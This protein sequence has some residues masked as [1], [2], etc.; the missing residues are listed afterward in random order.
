[1]QVSSN[2][3]VFRTFLVE[4]G[5]QAG[6]HEMLA[7]HLSKVIAKEVQ[8]KSAEILQ[9]AKDNS[10]H[11]KKEKEKLQAAYFSLEKSKLKYQKSFH[12][13]KEAERNYQIADQDG[14]IARNEILKMKMFTQSK[15]KIYENSKAQYSDQLVKTNITQ[16]EYFKSNLP[17]LVNSL[18]DLD[19]ERIQF[20]RR[21]M[22]RGLAA[23]REAVTISNKCREGME[24]A[25]K[26]IS[27]EKDQEIVMES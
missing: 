5:Y 23:E 10:K 12:D 26:G 17:G 25:I 20:V 9:N 13:W 6:Q 11:G 1:M 2:L 14:T 22:E 21:V 3:N 4:T 18:Q 15:C 24:D 8:S 19:R 16:R 7:E 27:E